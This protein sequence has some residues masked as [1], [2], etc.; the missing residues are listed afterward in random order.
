MR[1]IIVLVLIGFCLTSC[2]DKNAIPRGILD[3]DKMQVVLWD[4]IRAESFTNT[5]IKKDSTKNF[6]LEDAKLQLQVFAMH[7]VTKDEFYTSYDYYRMH[8]EL[9]SV[10]LDSINA[11]SM[12]QGNP[13]FKN[14]NRPPSFPG[15]HLNPHGFMHDSL[16]RLNPL[17]LKKK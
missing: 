6:I 10:V 9:M 14:N 17:L 5:Y 7:H 3:K 8:P 1:T 13:M 4:V 11:V 16:D 12:R 2:K 15:R